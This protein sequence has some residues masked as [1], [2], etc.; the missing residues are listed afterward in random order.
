[1]R[2][3]VNYIVT[4]SHELYTNSNVIIWTNGINGHG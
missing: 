1:M 2:R 3:D 4:Q